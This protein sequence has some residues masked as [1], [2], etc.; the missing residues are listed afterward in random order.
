VSSSGLLS[1]KDRDLL[2]GVQQRAIK[3][4][5][6]LEHLPCEEGLSNLGLISLGKRRL[7]WEPNKYL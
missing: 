1:S 6:G 7:R 3:M 5:K 2:E 4:I